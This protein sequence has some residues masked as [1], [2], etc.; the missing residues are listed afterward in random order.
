MKPVQNTSR[1]V[2]EAPKR[3]LRS[4]STLQQANSQP[5]ERAV[6]THV[7]YSIQAARMYH[8]RCSLRQRSRVILFVKQSP[9]GRPLL[10]NH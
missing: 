9:H 10:L 4:A 1:C 5:S 8:C 2:L 3:Q 7:C 6:E